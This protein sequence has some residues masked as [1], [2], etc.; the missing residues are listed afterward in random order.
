[1][2]TVFDGSGG[3]KHSHDDS[4]DSFEPKVQ[5]MADIIVERSYHVQHEHNDEWQRHRHA[6]SQTS[7]YADSPV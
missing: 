1:M 3:W 6:Q 7:I 2:K 4:K 5:K